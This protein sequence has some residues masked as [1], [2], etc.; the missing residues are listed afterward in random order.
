MNAGE[1]Y[2]N[3]LQVIGET[4]FALGTDISFNEIDIN[5]CYIRGTLILPNECELHIAEYVIT[6]PS[7]DRPKYR[8]HLQKTDGSLLARRDNVPH[9]P[10]LDTYPDHRHD[11][12]GSPYSSPPMDVKAVLESIV[13][14]VFGED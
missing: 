10:S 4:S 11:E 3:I 1:Y 9:F 8:Y 14:F 7:L 6:A 13:P 12:T 5:V 2:Q